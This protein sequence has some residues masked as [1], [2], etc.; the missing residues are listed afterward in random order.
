[1]SETPEQAIVIDLWTVPEDSREEFI[2][3]M[4]TMYER[5]RVLDGF[6]EGQILQGANPCSRPTRA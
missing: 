3:A 4:V 5:L 2:D 1:M 6:V